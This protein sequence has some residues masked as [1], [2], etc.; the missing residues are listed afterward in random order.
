MAE[1]GALRAFSTG[2]GD[3]CGKYRLQVDGDIL[4]TPNEARLSF[5]ALWQNP[6][7]VPVSPAAN[8]T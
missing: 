3:N 1:H 6:R 8:Q 4:D 2:P 5:Y 7:D